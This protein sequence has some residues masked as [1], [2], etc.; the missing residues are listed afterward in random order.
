M[1][2]HSGCKL[3]P[4]INMQKSC[5]LALRAVVLGSVVLAGPGGPASAQGLVPL[6]G[7]IFPSANDAGRHHM[8]PTGKPCLALSGF[9]KAQAIN[10]HIF[11]HWVGATNSCGK[12]IKLQVCYAKSLDCIAMDVPPWGHRSNSS[13]HRTACS[14]NSLP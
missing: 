4:G 2:V 12:D 7:N 14:S 8:S 6:T 1:C 5:Q 13:L 10:P 3:R 11:E 9:A